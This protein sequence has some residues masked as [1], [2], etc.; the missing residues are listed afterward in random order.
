MTQHD[1]EASD[2]LRRS[3]ASFAAERKRVLVA[4]GGTGGHL[5]PAEALAAAL[6]K[7]DV[8]VELVTDSRAARH[9]GAFA[10]AVH[11]IPS[12]TIRGKNPIALAHTGGMLGYGLLKAWVALPKLKPAVVV[13]FGGYPTI[14][15]LLAAVLRGIPTII[16]EQNA[17]M[18]RANRLLAPRVR[19]IAT[20]FPGIL[21]SSPVLAAKATHTGN[22]VRP[23][24]IAV[25]SADYPLLDTAGPL[26]LL[27]FGGSQGA[28][29][30]ADVVPSAVARL[31]PHLQMR[32]RIVQQA[33]DED[34]SR[35]RDA[36]Q[37]MQ[38]Q[39]EVAPFFADLPARMAASH[40][41]ISRSGAS[42][43]A[44]LA[45]IGRPAILVPLP[46]ALDQDQR[47]NAGVL[48]QAGGAI[49]LDQAEFTPDRMAAEIAAL[50]AEPAR[51]AAMAGAAKLVGSIEAAERLA[52][53]VL[54]VA[55][56]LPR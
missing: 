25:S 7:R 43:V 21:K 17:V 33:R 28:R 50:A 10:G 34:F 18:G 56:V 49:R 54:R 13:G 55:G 53:L 32:L 23:A 5:F 22:P 16:H 51:L 41:V 4:A 42:T 35:V 19:A 40:L 48:M 30:M 8:A 52:D 39:A 45:A 26:H 47:A 9:A 29:V 15:P 44:E 24:V 12:A 20:G 36:Y 3:D 31:E 6:G 46:H 1:N 38:V 27:V 37:K 11:V 14:P 2:R